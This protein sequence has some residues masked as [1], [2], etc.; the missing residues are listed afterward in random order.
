VSLS[1][2][3]VQVL[4]KK[5]VDQ[6][7]SYTKIANDNNIGVE[8]LKRE[9]EKLQKI[10]VIDRVK[11]FAWIDDNGEGSFAEYKPSAIN[12]L[13]ETEGVGANTNIEVTVHNL[14]DKM[15]EE[16]YTADVVEIV[17]HNNT[18]AEVTWK[19]IKQKLVNT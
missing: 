10:Q 6:N 15:T 7:L 12:Q 4:A 17:Q 2:Y 13:A 19:L 18:S 16:G 1:D 14:K 3:Q 5:V 8:R 9:V 11:Y